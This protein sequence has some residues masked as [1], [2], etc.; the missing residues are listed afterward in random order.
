MTASGRTSTSRQE[1]S[2][3]S[4]GNF[5]SLYLLTDPSMTLLMQL[6]SNLDDWPHPSVFESTRKW[7]ISPMWPRGGA[8]RMWSPLNGCLSFC[9]R[10]FWLQAE[11]QFNQRL[12]Q[13]VAKT[14]PRHNASPLQAPAQVRCVHSSYTT[15]E[16]NS[17]AL[18]DKLRNGVLCSSFCYLQNSYC[19]S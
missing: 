2:R 13:E 17:W 12:D 10:M 6:V 7:L 1:H 11:S 18:S 9:F 16:P 19:A 15:C 14:E 3:C 8:V 4:S 5:Q